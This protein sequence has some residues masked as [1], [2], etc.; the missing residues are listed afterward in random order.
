M[1]E[2]SRLNF[3]AR[4]H[5]PFDLPL[6][7]KTGGGVIFGNSGGVT[8][9][10]LRNVIHKSASD[11]DEVEE[12]SFVRGESGIR[13]AKVN[14]GGKELNIAVVHG[15]KNAR[16][17]IKTLRE[18]PKKYDFVEVMACPGGCI[19][20]AGQPVYKDPAVR[21]T[22]SKVLY[23]NDKTLELHKPQDNLYVQ[24][25]YDKYMEGKPGTH[26][27]H[28]LLHAPHF[29]R[30]RITEKP[31]PIYKPS[32][33]KKLGINV[34][35]GTGCIS[36]GSQKLLKEILGYIEAKDYKDNVG[37]DASFCFEKCSRGPVVK[38]G[39]QVIEKCDIAAAKTA[40]DEE[41]KKDSPAGV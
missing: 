35:F 12:F 5:T 2:E 1:R 39:S 22:R 41:I 36:R 34:C 32:K 4:E 10:V 38:I 15:L 25:V 20:G 24:Q 23:D 37:I 9:A 8:E 19:G 6:V 13:E 26:S 31:F 14:A 11:V 3:K 7:F 17:V 16:E 29:N 21:R 30:K 40:I 18:N 28:E 27:A 33:E